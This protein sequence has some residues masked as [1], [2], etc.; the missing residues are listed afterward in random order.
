MSTPKYPRTEVALAGED[1]NAFNI[2]GLVNR[3]LRKGRVSNAEVSAFVDEAT[4]G[5]YNHLLRVVQS[6]VTVK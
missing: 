2:L 5:D 3:A 4:K 1:G 6:W